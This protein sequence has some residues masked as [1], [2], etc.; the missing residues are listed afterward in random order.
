MDFYSS[1]AHGFARVAACTLPVAAADPARNADAVIEQARAC[2]AEGVALASFPELCLTGYAIDDLLLQDPLLDAAEEALARVVEASAD[3]LP[4]L[5]VGL[6]LVKDARLF[7]CA[8]VVHRGAILG[9]APKAYLPT[10]REFYERRHFAAGDD[11]RRETID[12]AGWRVPFGTDLLFRATDLEG[13]VVGVEVC[14]DMWIPVPPSAEAALAGATVLVNISG[15]PITVGRA[16]DRHLLC[17]SASARCLAAYLYSAAGEG[18]STTDLSW[19]GQTMI[20][21]RGMLLAETE[22]FPEG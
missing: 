10:Y 17:R 11:Q 14:E 19:D 13:F 9:V 2:S 15:S 22:R 12:V 7:N 5:V 1:Y 8:V 6:P 3:L 20:Y 21:E 4:V 16:E 18:E